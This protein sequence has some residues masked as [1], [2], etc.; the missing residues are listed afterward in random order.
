MKYSLEFLLIRT[1]SWESLRWVIIQSRKWF[2]HL[3]QIRRR[4]SLMLPVCWV[5]IVLIDCTD[6]LLVNVSGYHAPYPEFAFTNA[7]PTGVLFTVFIAGVQE[8]VY[9]FIRLLKSEKEAETL[10]KENLQTQLDSLKQQV[11]PHF[12]FNSLNTLSYLIGDDTERAEDFLN[13]LCKVY[14]YLLRANEHEL[15]DLSTE[16]QF[17]RSYFHLL[18]TRYGDNLHLQ[19]DIESVY[20]SYLLPSLTLQLLVENAVKHNV[21]DKFQPLTVSIHTQPDG[22]LTVRNNLQKKPQSLVSTQIGLRNITTKF[23]LLGQGDI[24]IDETDDQFAVII[25]L[26][27]ADNVSVYS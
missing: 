2:P 21:I 13:E 9:Y 5:L 6:M 25:P 22:T 18:K 23:R 8:A 27:Q 15:I 7:L 26:I 4:V 24:R 11:N 17:I 16:L 1:A 3:S 20:E 10:K 19:I 12:L 14:R